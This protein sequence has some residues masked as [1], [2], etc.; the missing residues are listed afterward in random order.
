[1]IA[2]IRNAQDLVIPKLWPSVFV[3]AFA[4]VVLIMLAI[5]NVF[6]VQVMSSIFFLFFACLAPAVAFGGLL[7]VVT[8]GA[9][10]TIEASNGTQQ[11]YAR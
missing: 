5:C 10:G 2:C 11:N 6:V 7:G 4:F 9:M 3:M 1:M 8:S